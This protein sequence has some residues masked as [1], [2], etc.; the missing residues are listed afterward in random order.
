MSNKI[1]NSNNVSGMSQ[2][3]QKFNFSKIIYTSDFLKLKITQFFNDSENQFPYN[4][5][6]LKVTFMDYIDEI[7]SITL[8]IYILSMLDHPHK[9]IRQ[10]AI[11]FVKQFS[12]LLMEINLY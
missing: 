7:D 10:E 9:R 6:N 2:N 12:K 1:V 11:C 5:D 3:I 8:T 4:T